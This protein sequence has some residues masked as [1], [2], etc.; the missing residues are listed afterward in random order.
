MN[1][2]RLTRNALLLVVLGSLAVWASRE[3]QKS[4]S[5]R[6]AATQVPVSEVLPE[7]E[8][9]QVT[10]TYFL[11][12]ARCSSCRKIEALA[13][14]TVEQDFAA[15]VAS[16][17]LVFRVI[18]TEKPEN[19]HYRDD[20]KLTSKTVV[21]GRRIDG[22]ETAWKDMD[23]VWELLNDGPAYHRYLGDQI[24]EYLKS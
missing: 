19:R 21:I 20:Y 24:R 11:I 23:Q 8:G 13:R 10:M 9:P 16:H 6:E 17:N 18:D 12:G 15:E 5:Y 14:Q 2:K 1:A 4:K 3:I 22:K 7:A